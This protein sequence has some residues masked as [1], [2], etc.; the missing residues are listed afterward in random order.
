MAVAAAF[1]QSVEQFGRPLGLADVQIYRPKPAFHRIRR[2]MRSRIEQGHRDIEIPEG[3]FCPTRHPTQRS[4]HSQ[5]QKSRVVDCLR[6]FDQFLCPRDRLV[7]L[8]SEAEK[9]DVCRDGGGGVEVAAVG[10]PAERRAQIGQFDGEPLIRLA[11]ARAV[12][13]R[14]DVGLAARE[15]AGM[16]R[17]RLRRPRRWRRVV[18]SANWRIVSSI[19]NRVRPVDRSATSN[20]LRTS[21]SSRSRTANSSSDPATARAALTSRSRRRTPN[22]VPAAPSP[23][24]RAGRRTTAPH[25]A[26]SGGAPD[27]AATRP[28]AGTGRRGGRAPRS[29]S[30]TPS[31]TPPTRSPAESH[32][33]DGRPP[34]PPQRS[35][36]S[37]EQR[38]VGALP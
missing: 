13:Q 2:C 11:L 12:P 8:D 17:A 6:R 36:S 25:G 35:Q 14:Q 29:R 10:S 18:S 9:P 19:E 22:T 16:Q 28:A 1:E 27:R 4:D 24:R 33:G 38:D 37:T 20:D 15:V 5:V 7:V 23:P 31:A 3:G 30:S 21:A 26:V 32:R 34:R